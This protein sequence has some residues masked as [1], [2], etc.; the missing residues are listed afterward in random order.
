[1]KK[2]EVIKNNLNNYN[3]GTNTIGIMCSEYKPTIVLN[4]KQ[5]EVPVK[6]YIT[7]P[8]PLVAEPVLKPGHI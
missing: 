8:P 3:Q 4:R 6:C 2:D 7:L 5:T 1:L